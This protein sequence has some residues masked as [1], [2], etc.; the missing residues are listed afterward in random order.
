MQIREI[1][2]IGYGFE[3]APAFD[4]WTA[5]LKLGETEIWFLKYFFWQYAFERQHVVSDFF[6]NICLQ[7]FWWVWSANQS[8]PSSLGQS[9]SLKNKQKWS[10][11]KM[12]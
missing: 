7:T 12:N 8:G 2:W 9:A 11:H 6:R 10:R 1:S 5:V 4:M 3:N